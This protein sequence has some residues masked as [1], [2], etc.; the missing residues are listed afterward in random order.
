VTLP[1]GKQV[2]IDRAP[3]ADERYNDVDFA[4][5]DA[6]RRARRGLQDRVRR[7]QGAVKTHEAQPVGTV[8][9]L[10]DGYGFLQTADGRDVYFHRNSVLDGAFQRLKI[11]SSVSFVEEDGEKGPQAST[12]RVQ[13]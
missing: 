9:R 7:L 6:F 8:V 2:D 10:H 13:D 5:N 3:E 12:V 4:L 1:D 11:G